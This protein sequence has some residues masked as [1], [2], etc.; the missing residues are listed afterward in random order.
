MKYAVYRSALWGA[1]LALG[2]P[3][4]GAAPAPA[5][6]G[7]A[8]DGG[9]VVRDAAM[10]RSDD[11]A[12]VEPSELHAQVSGLAGKGLRL[13]SA[14]GE[15]ISVAANGTVA[16][17]APSLEGALT[18]VA[19]P[20]APAQTCSAS[21]EGAASL[22][23]RCTTN[24]YAIGGHAIGVSGT[25]LVLTSSWGESLAIDA[26][27]SFR[28]EQ[29]LADLE[30]YSLTIESSPRS[31]RQTCT[32][33][34]GEG[35]I[36]GAD[37]TD[38]SVRCVTESY[39][40]AGT[41]SGLQGKG[42][43]IELNGQTTLAIAS[44]GPF[45]FAD[46]L[47]D[48]S[49][50]ALRV[51][52]QPKSPEQRC[53][54]VGGEA[55]L[56]G[57]DVSDVAVVCGALGG[58]R[59][60]EVG[61][62]YF[63]NSACWFE[64]Y[65]AGDVVEDISY[66]QVRTPSS[67]RTAPYIVSESRLFSLPSAS[68]APG[69]YVLVRARSSGALPDGQGVVHIAD[70][71]HLPWWNADG[72]V[73]LL[74]S[75]VSVDFV[76]F[77]DSD[78][79]LGKAGRF[80]G[81]NAPSLP[82]G[83]DDYGY[84]I[85]RDAASSDRDRGSDWLVRA[86]ATPGGPN[87]VSSDA[88]V[89][90]DGVPD[91]A[92]VAGGKFAGIDLYA[93]GARVGPRDLF[94]EVDR[95][96]SSDAAVL[97]R[98]EALDKVARVF[99]NRGFALHFDAGD[100]FASGFDPAQYNLGGGNVVPYAKAIAF[101]GGGAYANIYAYKAAHMASA[102]RSV[103]YYMLFAWSQNESGS[104]GSSGIGERPGNDTI[105]TL[106]GWGLDTST[107]A[108]K[109]LLINYQA[110]TMMHELGHNLSLRHGGGDEL[111][112]KPNYVSVMNYLYSPLGLPTIGRAEGDRYDLS[113]R[114]SIFSVA[115]LTNPPT[116]S[117]DAFVLDFSDGYSGDL[118]ESSLLENDGLGRTDSVAVDFNCNGKS[119][120]P[121]ARDVN[122]D[123]SKDLLTD[124]DDWSNLE[125]VFRRSYSGNENGSWLWLWHSATTH[126]DVSTDDVQRVSEEPCP[127]PAL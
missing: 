16:F 76:R 83:R 100:L 24:R 10:P 69:G 102:R 105:I 33:E 119:D 122:N 34:H 68:V 91:S 82:T 73:E 120:Q 6:V 114:C 40:L 90:R 51:K 27:G 110:A 9:E 121:Y 94:I 47:L 45:A 103:F 123:D 44:D 116:G 63:A 14:S 18:V 64:L 115:L 65:N 32:L 25:G 55:T 38:V 26:S 78:A 42:L 84:A 5:A 96:D 126:E 48:G 79:T 36:A 127:P 2:A 107:T 125:L 61:S 86:F 88:D 85:A 21:F 56:A 117:P 67:R 72:F 11:A 17:H 81:A 77:G 49:A 80:S 57:A 70:G 23:V 39:G 22:V 108:R 89:D 50:Y 54:V 15:E 74:S 98:R 30:S 12:R 109:N 4:C 60:N 7:I 106:G 1:L 92:E 13:R 59:I 53:V 66:Y 8:A 113:A 97:P 29:T 95:M 58:L 112:R 41:V 87:D 20:V 43:V 111:N 101:G 19:Q 46:K 3:A 99:A 37:A 28:F 71:D 75:G 62:C 118:L 52:Q 104:G 31:P 124:Y 35:T 93:M